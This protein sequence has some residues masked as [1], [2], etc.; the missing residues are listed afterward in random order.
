LMVNSIGCF[1]CHMPCNTFDLVG[2]ISN[3]IIGGAKVLLLKQAY[4]FDI[5]LPTVIRGHDYLIAH[6]T[7]APILRIPLTT[8]ISTFIYRSEFPRPTIN[9]KRKRE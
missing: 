2:E 5:T 8:D 3:M 9:Q 6:Q 7:H 1:L 4:K